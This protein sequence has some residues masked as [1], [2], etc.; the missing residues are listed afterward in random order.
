[1]KKRPVG[2]DR[3]LKVICAL[4][5]ASAILAI[6]ANAQSPTNTQNPI[7]AKIIL[8]LNES[9]AA[10]QRNDCFT[11]VDKE[12]QACTLLKANPSAAP[13]NNYIDLCCVLL[14]SLDKRI[15]ESSLD[16]ATKAIAAKQ[17]LL[18]AMVAWEPQN[19]RW[20][21]E[22]GVTSQKLSSLNGDKYSQTLNEAL[23]EFQK[24]LAIS[25]G[26]SYHSA[27]MQE[28]TTCQ[29]TIKKLDAEAAEYQRTHQANNSADD[30]PRFKN[31]IAMYYKCETCGYIFKWAS[32]PNHYKMCSDA[33]PKPWNP[34]WNGIRKFADGTYDV[35]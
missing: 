24:A 20:H 14:H 27:I 26:G 6:P 1:M 30:I 23:A 3:M 28:I 8:L 12:I 17:R 29:N 2:I 13:D 16:G 34:G 22:K 9:T 25:G 11:G 5:I 10:F 15:Q 21:Y 32:I 18:D 31:G 33:R 4:I 19:Q 35:P 7:T